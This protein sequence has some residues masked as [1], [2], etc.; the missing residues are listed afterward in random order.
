MSDERGAS[1][2]ASAYLFFLLPMAILAMAVGLRASGTVE[3]APSI[4]G[5][6]RAHLPVARGVAESEGVPLDLLLAVA[7]AES[8]GHADARS[9]QGAVGLMQL[10]AGTASDMAKRGRETVEPDR[11]DPNV[12]LRLGARYL[13]LQRRRFRDHPLSEELA[14]CAYNAGPARVSSWLQARPVDPSAT[15]LGTWIRY[16]ETR[17]Y[18]KRVGAWQQRWAEILAAERDAPGTAPE[19]AN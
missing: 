16:S 14:L 19:P 5:R 7:S 10:L 4:V 6:L 2:L 3:S 18:V 9:P 1:G 15:H 17:A 12:S 8:A 11:L 13:A